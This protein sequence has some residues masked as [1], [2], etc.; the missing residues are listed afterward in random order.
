MLLAAQLLALTQVM[1]WRV[2]IQLCL[3]ATQLPSLLRCRVDTSWMPLPLP[4]NH[5]GWRVLMSSEKTYHS[6]LQFPGGRKTEQTRSSL[7]ICPYLLSDSCVPA[8]LTQKYPHFLSTFSDNR[9]I[10][11]FLDNRPIFWDHCLVL[12]VLC[13]CGSHHC[14]SL[15]MKHDSASEPAQPSCSKDLVCHDSNFTGYSR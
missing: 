15:C 14:C 7:C 8:A 5:S 12:L 10:F 13:G 3:L 9:S 1:P 11:W 2:R 6:Q 4:F